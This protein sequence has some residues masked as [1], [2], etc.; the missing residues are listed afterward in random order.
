MS[1]KL[2][3]SS[4]YEDV[5]IKLINSVGQTIFSKKLSTTITQ[6]IEVIRTQDL[7]SGNYLIKV[8]TMD[9]QRSVSVSVIK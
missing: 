1:V 4:T 8:E 2:D 9:G 5:R 7:P 3:F 6:H